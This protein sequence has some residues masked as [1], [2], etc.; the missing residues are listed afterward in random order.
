MFLVALSFFFLFE[1]VIIST[2][3][4]LENIDK[5]HFLENKTKELN[6]QMQ[7]GKH[8]LSEM[9]EVL[10]DTMVYDPKIS[11][12]MHQATITTDLQKEALLRAELY[13]L[14]Q[15]KY[16][17]MKK[18]GVRQ[19]HFH[20]PGAV[21]FLRFH[22]VEKFGDSL[23][24]IR[25]SLMYVNK[26]KK[27]VECFEEGRIFNGFRHVYPLFYNKEFVGSV[28]ISYSFKAFLNHMLKINPNASY[29]FLMNQEVIDTKV[30]DDEKRNYI[31]SDFD[32]YSIDKN[33]LNNNMGISLD[34]IF[35]IN[36]KISKR[37]SKDLQKK[38]NFT[39]DTFIGQ[40][41][42][43][44]VLVSF[45]GIKNFEEK[46][47]AYMVG[48]SYSVTMDIFNKRATQ[49]ALLLT[50]VNVVLTLLLIILFRNEKLKTQ[51]A[52]EEAIHDPLTG[53]LNRRG[54][55]NILDYKASI[56]RRYD[57]DMSVIFFDIDHFK[58]VNDSYGHDIGDTILQEISDVIKA[59]IRESDIFA[60]WGG[61]EFILVLPQTSMQEGV[62]LAEKLRAEIKRYHFTKV[63]A[64]TCSFGVTQL[65]DD[66]SVDELL[67]RA[68]ELLYLA[69]TKGRD[70]VV[71]D[72]E[73]STNLKYS[74]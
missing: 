53:V 50:F 56:S 31:K 49:M 66:E 3:K 45:I 47:V 59:N 30:F 58:E 65:H 32:G 64:L 23:A 57:S 17:Y 69:K 73:R 67:K 25:E 55:D 62:I 70:R 41:Q 51:R 39:V 4:Y 60:R 12:I 42:N 20:A 35:A 54:F 71:S 63:E 24:G 27:P 44:S 10:Y 19:L 6:V 46:K 16:E 21:S 14:L 34:E 61:E 28:E 29:L 7:M 74:L 68:D 2:V 18:L 1:I 38:E 36:K 11:E 48:Y 8:Y 72:T 26:S 15:K 5:S 40:L 22:R 52:S 37:I 9:A 33:T 13:Q 43:K